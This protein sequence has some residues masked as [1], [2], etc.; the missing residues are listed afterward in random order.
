[1]NG[2]IRCTLAAIASVGLSGCAPS[3]DS[4][5]V[6]PGPDVNLVNIEAVVR[7][8]AAV[9]LDT[10]TVSVAVLPAATP[11]FA[12]AG[13]LTY[14]TS[15][16]Y[17]RDGLAFVPGQYRARVTAPYQVLLL[18]GTRTK[19][20]EVDFTIEQPEGC[21]FF[22]PANGGFTAD[23]FFQ[24]AA[25]GPQDDG[26]RTDI[27]P[28]QSPLIVQGTNAPQQ[29]SSVL[30]GGF[31]SLGVTL[32]SPCF[33]S[34]TPD[35]ASDLVVVDFVSP[36]LTGV[37]GWAGATGFEV[38]AIANSLNVLASNPIRL[39][40]IF[41]DTSGQAR[42]EVTAN[43]TRVFH[44]LSAAFQTIGMTRPGFT[45]AQVRARMFVPVGTYSGEEYI[46]IDRVCPRS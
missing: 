37:G 38:M 2:A 12:S 11:S 21:F 17:R 19:T 15:N 33:S 34:S 24:I 16:A 32:G 26:T 35:P 31:R 1:M 42:P 36:D 9:D 7:G 3:I 5:T 45:V 22:D 13:D 41:T 39:Q 40:L 30:P 46:A 10:P 4:V 27:C 6:T 20:R 29:Y 25:A 18:P 14:T 23:G 8:A 28:N 43:G 44:D